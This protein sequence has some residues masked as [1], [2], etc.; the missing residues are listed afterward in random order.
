MYLHVPR[1][2]LIPNVQ[3]GDMKENIRVAAILSTVSLV[4]FGVSA[5]I[6]VSFAVSVERDGCGMGIGLCAM[7]MCIWV[8]VT[9]GAGVACAI[10][11]VAVTR[12]WRAASIGL[13]VL[14]AFVLLFFGT[15]IGLRLWHPFL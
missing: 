14:H 4:F 15:P 12:R 1:K 7:V 13:I 8:W 10:A 3:W 5:A 11:C 9:S 6:I 2:S